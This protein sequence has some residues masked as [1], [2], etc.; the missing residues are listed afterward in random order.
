MVEQ[1][2]L[3][4][5]LRGVGACR[6]AAFGAGGATREGGRLACCDLG[7]KPGRARDVLAFRIVAQAQNLTLIPLSKLFGE[8]YA[9]YRKVYYSGV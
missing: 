1:I 7:E 5:L 9:V 6:L 3:Q 2:S 4:K 8:R